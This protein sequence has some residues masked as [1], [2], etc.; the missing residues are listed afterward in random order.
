MSGLGL[1]W[2]LFGL[3][4]DRLGFFL[5]LGL[6]LRLRLRDFTEKSYVSNDLALGVVDIPVC[7]NLFAGALG[8]I[9]VLL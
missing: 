3:L 8:D 5:S 4:D 6:G 1:F 9:A 7:V 2:R